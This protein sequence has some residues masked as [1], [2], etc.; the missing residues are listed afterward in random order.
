MKRNTIR[1]I[2]ILCV[3]LL[4]IVQVFPLEFECQFFA[5]NIENKV[6][7]KVLN[8]TGIEK[9]IF[10]VFQDNPTN[11]GLFFK[12]SQ[13]N[14]INN[15]LGKIGSEIKATGVDIDLFA[16]MITRKFNWTSQPE[17]FDYS[18]EKSKRKR[19][20]KYD[21]FN[22]N[23]VKK[24]ITIYRELASKPIE[25]ILIQDDFFIRYNEGLSNWGK[26]A[27]TRVTQLPAREHLM[28][29]TDSPYNKKWRQIKVA[30][31]NKVLKEI[32]SNVKEVKPGI[33][34]GMNIYYETP[35][36]VENA[37][38]WYAHDLKGIVES[39][40]DYIYLMSYQR[41]IKNEMKLDESN[42]R[43]LF[44]KIVNNALKICKDKLI[45]KLQLRDWKT[46]KRVPASEIISYLDIVPREVKRVCFTPVKPGDSEY[47]KKIIDSRK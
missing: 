14:T 40:L 13:Y 35:Y 9:I 42:N 11:G 29:K 15:Y 28:T 1:S 39:G 19:V 46:G 7:Y 18:F 8:G 21:I 22:P 33:K 2:G 30:Q 20:L 6:D 47:L 3:S 23:A 31:V 26:A 37:E 43:M 17:L 32:V 5:V 44:W 38:K 34:I 4:V 10:R 41:Q 25:G 36:Y 24:I 45:V 16:W 12:N 27:F